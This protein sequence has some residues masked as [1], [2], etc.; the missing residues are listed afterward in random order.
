MKCTCKIIDSSR[1][2]KFQSSIRRDNQNPNSLFYFHV[3]LYCNWSKIIFIIINIIFI[4]LFSGCF[5]ISWWYSSNKIPIKCLYSL[6]LWRNEI[7]AYFKLNI[8]LSNIY[9]FFIVLRTSDLIRCIYWISVYHVYA[10]D[11]I[12]I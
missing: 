9:L 4:H 5:R 12:I 8:F 10:V 11:I 3:N 6:F 7:S 2:Y 1:T